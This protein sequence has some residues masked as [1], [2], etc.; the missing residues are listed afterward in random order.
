ML[1]SDKILNMDI[2]KYKKQV[3]KWFTNMT[4]EKMLT[5]ILVGLVSYVTIGFI[6]SALKS[7]TLDTEKEVLSDSLESKNV[8]CS[9]PEECSTENTSLPLEE[10]MKLTCCNLPDGTNK[11]IS[12]KDC[13]DITKQHKESLEKSLEDAY[14]NWTADIKKITKQNEEYTKKLFNVYEDEMDKL[15]DTCNGYLKEYSGKVAKL[16][17][18]NNAIE[19]NYADS[20]KDNLQKLEELRLA[21]LTACIESA[22]NTYK[23]PMIGSSSG[24]GNGYVV[25]ESKELTYKL[26]SAISRCNSLYGTSYLK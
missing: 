3:I 21:N 8:M 13:I 19:N 14:K 1:K 4:L 18:E 10:C 26:N 22:K 6:V 24:S 9:F 11:V 20:Q 25:G 17:S 15:V 7:N 2:G 23:Q 16:S 12:N 5:V